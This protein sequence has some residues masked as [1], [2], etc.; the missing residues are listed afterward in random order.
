MAYEPKPGQF[1]LFKNDKRGN[2]KA[3]D[4]AGDG[5]DL[6]GSR[7]K[8]AAWLKEGKGGKFMSCKLSYPQKASESKPAEKPDDD[9]IP[10]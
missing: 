2:E 6:Q 4:Y 7:V 9:G 1:S 10:F 5:L 3:P 8:V